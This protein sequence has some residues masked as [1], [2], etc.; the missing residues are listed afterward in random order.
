M[1]KQ[2]Y[3]ILGFH[4]GINNN[5]DPKDIRDIEMR[6]ADGVSVHKIGKLITIGNKD[7][8]LANISGASADIEPGYGLYF[9]STDYDSSEANTSEDWLA[10]YNK[11]S[12]H[13]LRFYYRDKDGNSPNFISGGNEVT[14]GSGTKPNFYFAD[15][16]LR[17]GDSSFTNV[18]KYFG[19]IDNALFWTTTSGAS[20][21]LHD[22]H[23][24][25]N[26]IQEIKPLDEL[27]GDPD[28]LVLFNGQSSSPED[29]TARTHIHASNK[30]IVLSYWTNEGG[31]WNGTYEFAATPI[32]IGEQEGP[33]ATFRE[34]INTIST[35]NFYNEEV[36]FQTFI[37]TGENNASGITA[38]ANHRLGDDRIIGVNNYFRKQGDEDWT[39]L[40]KTD[41]TQGGKH[42][43]KLY[44]SDTQ[45]NY[46]YWTGHEITASGSGA[47][48][49]VFEG[50]DIMQDSNAGSDYIAFY[51]NANGTNNDTA[52]DWMDGTD[53][54]SGQDGKSFANV[55]L[56]V[57]LRNTNVNGF[58]DRFGFLRVWGGANS[59]LYVNTVSGSQ[60][61]LK[62]NDGTDYDTYYVPFTLPGIGTGRE[63]RVELLD[64]NF[65]VIADS[66][67]KTMD[68]KDSGRVA[69]ENYEQQVDHSV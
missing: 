39:F 7:S 44:N 6:E 26:D 1:P 17:I 69:P 23:K 66:G 67:I 8:A 10:V 43:W 28:R 33:I 14:M 37:S 48:Q 13:K 50:I 35:A 41:L 4:G 30:Q 19:Y 20:Q 16:F 34:D 51:D 31:D 22:I 3:S 59:P 47:P 45:T 58:D 12:A 68:I 11:G 2:E 62:T 27:L 32:I 57:K 53:G 64:E 36:I 54:G 18:S 42:Y 5:S 63:F 56:R 40:M 9:F 65:T 38:D 55:Y 60:I 29:G 46:G 49:T 24:W 25:K 15:G 61:P 21:N 52:A